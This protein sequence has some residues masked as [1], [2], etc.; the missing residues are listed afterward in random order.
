M[1][2]ERVGVQRWLEQAEDPELKAR[3][4]TD[5][6]RRGAF[7]ELVGQTR[8]SLEELYASEL[9]DE[10]K[11]A[12]KALIFERLRSDYRELRRRWNGYAGYDRWFE[13]DLNNAKL[14]L[15]AT[16]NAYVPALESLLR[17]KGGDLAAFN[18]ACEVLAR[19]PAED[20]RRA[21]ERLAPR[22]SINRA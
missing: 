10:Q 15:I 8:S 5:Q 17:Q 13:S 6:E 20:R 1:V 4:G 7:L 9:G 12:K 11:R 2:V 21:L 22:Q 18:A 19:M 3:Y 16:Y 14:A